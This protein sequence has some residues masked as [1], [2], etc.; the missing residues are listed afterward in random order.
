MHVVAGRRRRRSPRAVRSRR[1]GRRERRQSP[2]VPAPH[3][4]IVARS[5]ARTARRADP[6]LGTF[7]ALRAPVPRRSTPCGGSAPA[8]P[9][10]AVRGPSPAHLRRVCVYVFLA[11]RA[12]TTTL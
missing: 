11:R 6:R 4:R 7:G 12:L 10:K 3:V 5:R 1:G 2:H 8:P 9:G